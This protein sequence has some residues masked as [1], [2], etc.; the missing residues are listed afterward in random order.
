M[1]ELVSKLLESFSDLERCIGVTKEM[2]ARKS[3]VPAEVHHRV[4]QY[5]EIVEKQRRLALD[6]QVYIAGE[7]WPEVTR[8]VKLINGLSSMIRDDAQSITSE[9]A[10]ALAANRSKPEDYIF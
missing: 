5:A 8:C 10:S 3:G 6:M 4:A 2:L 1:A 7:N 9:A